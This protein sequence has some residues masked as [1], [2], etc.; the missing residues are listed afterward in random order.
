MSK[1]KKTTMQPKDY[2][3]QVVESSEA[4]KNNSNAQA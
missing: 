4:Y 1:K 3:D 2:K